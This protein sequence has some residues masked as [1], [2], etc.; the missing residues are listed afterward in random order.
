MSRVTNALRGHWSLVIVLMLAVILRIAFWIAL[1]PA[2][3]FADSWVYL[4]DSSPIR[5]LTYRPAGYVFLLAALNAKQSLGLI[6]AL[7]HL[8]GLL[9]GILIY[10]LCVRKGTPRHLAAGAAALF[11]FSAFTLVLEQYLLTEAFFA[12]VLLVSLRF[13]ILYPHRP[14]QLA[15]SG[16]F[17]ALAGLLRGAGI[18]ALP[19][20][21]GWL[22]LHNRKEMKVLVA[23]MLAL[24]LPISAYVVVRNLS[25]NY[26]SVSLH[27]GDGWFL[28]GRAMSFAD[29]A[30]LELP[31]LISP[32]CPVDKPQ[33]IP[34]WYVW[35][36]D[37]PA[38]TFYKDDKP[39]YNEV[40][41][42]IAFRIISRQPGDYVITVIRDI[43]RGFVPGGGGDAD[44]SL[45]LTYEGGHAYPFD[46]E[47]PAAKNISQRLNVNYRT[48]TVAPRSFL[49]FWWQWARIPRL[50]LGLLGLAAIMVV[51]KRSW[52]RRSNV[53]AAIFLGIS[54]FGMFA[55]SVAL[56]AFELRYIVPLVPLFATGGVISLSVICQNRLL[57]VTISRSKGS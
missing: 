20:W 40:V 18:F 13:A 4:N 38:R 29:C 3:M 46:I 54:A 41:R 32:L 7:Q 52:R 24:L 8:A 48:P 56:S 2:L 44:A 39:E 21:A 36:P 31:D 25:T 14:I 49:A 45:I 11:L 6:T 28:Y 35:S 37:S 23:P 50:V 17:L 42:S 34:E 16:F 30:A 26:G 51:T 43:L 22:I 19:F 27:R 12:L 5:F 53:A 1:K 57:P 10:D 47:W 55:F 15:I 9:T 33:N